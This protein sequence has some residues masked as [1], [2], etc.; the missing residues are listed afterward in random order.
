[1]AQPAIHVRAL[2]IL[3]LILVGA[4]LLLN[5][6]KVKEGFWWRRHGW[7]RPWWRRPWWSYPRSV[8]PYPYS[9][10]VWPYGGGGGWSSDGIY[11]Y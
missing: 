8:P 11:T 1:M 3:I 5:M 4:Y 9:W 10:S 6:E 7:R 2:V